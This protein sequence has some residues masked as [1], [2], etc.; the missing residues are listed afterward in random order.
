MHLNPAGEMVRAVW[1]DIPHFYPEV[2]VDA[3]AV[4]PNHIH[5][6]ILLGVGAGPRACPENYQRQPRGVAPTFSLPAV[7]HRFKSFTTARYRKENLGN[8]ILQGRL[9]QRNYYEHVIRDEEELQKIREYII[10]NPMKWPT[11]RDNPEISR[12]DLRDEMD[13]ILSDSNP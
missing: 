4:M 7:V 3:F 1:D 11:D 10:Y 6:I 13:I 2:D 12:P 9:W 5:G 8:Q